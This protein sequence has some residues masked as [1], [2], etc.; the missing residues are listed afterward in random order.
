MVKKKFK[1]VY[2]D[3]ETEAVVTVERE[4]EDTPMVSAR[5]WAEDLAYALA[6]KGSYAIQEIIGEGV[7]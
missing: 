5:E 4:F 7:K 2:I 6:D 1:I 3:P